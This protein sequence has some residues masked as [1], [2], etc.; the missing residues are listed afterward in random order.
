[1]FVSGWKKDGPLHSPAVLWSPMSAKE[2]PDRKRSNYC[3]TC[4]V[5][6]PSTFEVI[7]WSKLLAKLQT[8]PLLLLKQ[9]FLCINIETLLKLRLSVPEQKKYMNLFFQVLLERLIR[10]IYFENANSPILSLTLE[11]FFHKTFQGPKMYK[12]RKS[13]DVTRILNAHYYFSEFFFSF[14]SWKNF[15]SKGNKVHR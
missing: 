10:F 12:H 1:M 13:T 8:N 3:K 15:N 7:V 9:W 11:S 6:A 4:C 2:N 5:L 14:W